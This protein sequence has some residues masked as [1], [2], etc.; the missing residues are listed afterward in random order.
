MTL[1][2]CGLH[3]VLRFFRIKWQMPVKYNFCVIAVVISTGALQLIVYK[4]LNRKTDSF[5]PFLQ[6]RQTLLELSFFE[7]LDLRFFQ[8]P[9]GNTSCKKVLETML[10][11]QI[12]Y[13][14]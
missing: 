2:K 10:S 4:Y 14:S 9:H 6:I 7:G 5:I 3:N 8:K 11:E 13:V 1:W 12:E